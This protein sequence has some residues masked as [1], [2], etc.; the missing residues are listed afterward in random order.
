MG[1]TTGSAHL[2][3]EVRAILSGP[4]FHMLPKE[5]SAV[6]DRETLEWLLSWLTWLATPFMW[7]YDVSPFLYYGVVALVFL[8][9][10][11]LILRLVQMFRVAMDPMRSVVASG[12]E[13]RQEGP[14]DMEARARAMAE[15]GRWDEALRWLLAAAIL[16][17]EPDASRRRPGLTNRMYVRRHQRSPIGSHLSVLVDAFDRVWYGGRSL[18]AT[19]YGPCEQAYQRLIEQLAGRAR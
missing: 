2:D 13:S 8:G 11:L 17:V 18:D 14:G 16:R 15:Q 3:A 7:I 1:L 5:S 4:D 12:H 9:L 10:V 19:D 6:L